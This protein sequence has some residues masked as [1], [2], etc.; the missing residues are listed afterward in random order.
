MRNSRKGDLIQKKRWIRHC[1]FQLFSRVY[2]SLFTHA[3]IVES[4]CRTCETKRRLLS[5]RKA[6]FFVLKLFKN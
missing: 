5:N 2:I 4:K 3:F 1:V 6:Y